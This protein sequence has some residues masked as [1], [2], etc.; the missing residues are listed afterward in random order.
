MVFSIGSSLVVIGF[1][2]G[3]VFGDPHTK[4]LNRCEAVGA[5]MMFIGLL[6]ASVSILMT[7]A[8]YLV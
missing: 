8:K 7:A 5:T 3:T 2:L 4:V 1:L 6:T